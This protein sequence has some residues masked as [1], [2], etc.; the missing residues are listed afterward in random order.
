MTG[1]E[2]SSSNR[3][4]RELFSLKKAGKFF[5]QQRVFYRPK[6][7]KMQQQ[8]AFRD[9]MIRQK[10]ISVRKKL[11]ILNLTL[12]PQSTIIRMEP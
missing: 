12:F 8:R 7:E 2:L 3:Q 11:T 10:I 4:S 1:G 6:R 9:E 5:S